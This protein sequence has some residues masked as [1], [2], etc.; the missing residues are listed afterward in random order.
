MKP[1][2][3]LGFTK[4]RAISMLHVLQNSAWIVESCQIWQ[5]TYNIWPTPLPDGSNKQIHCLFTSISA[6]ASTMDSVSKPTT[7]SKT[8]DYLLKSPQMHSY[9]GSKA[10]TSELPGHIR[11]QGHLNHGLQPLHHIL[12]RQLKVKKY[13]KPAELKNVLAI[14]IWMVTHAV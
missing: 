3:Y 4:H 10:K 6:N 5:A 9:S 8:V 14:K 13:K 11:A 1:W 12:I 7:C 2:S